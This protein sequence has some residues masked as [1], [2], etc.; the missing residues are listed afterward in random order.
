MSFYS[1]KTVE[2]STEYSSHSK[3]IIS[4]WEC[5]FV[6][7]CIV[8]LV[9]CLGTFKLFKSPWVHIWNCKYNSPFLHLDYFPLPLD[10][11]INKQSV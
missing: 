1:I 8:V 4:A 7:I 2:L 11:F 9:F 5:M 10:F 3:V 6:F